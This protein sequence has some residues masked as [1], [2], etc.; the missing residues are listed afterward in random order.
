MP[1]PAG[2]RPRSACPPCR[3]GDEVSE[4]PFLGTGWRFPPE[5]G[6]GTVRMSRDE[7]DIE[8]SLRILFG[9]AAGERFLR[10]D[11]GLSLRELQFEP[12]STTLRHLLKDRIATAV[13]I[14][15]PRIRVIDLDVASP[16]AN[17][18]SLQIRLDYEVR[19][20][21]SRFN[22]VF[23]FYATDANERRGAVGG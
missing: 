15:E 20:T 6:G 13:L 11:Y 7:E 1:A 21:N 16:D 4:R 19:A 2:P 23:P 12:M 8:A 14:H 5:F 10:P 18:G 9:T 22:L 3:S 17:D